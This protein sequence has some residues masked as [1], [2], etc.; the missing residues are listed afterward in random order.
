LREPW[1]RRLQDWWLA[2][3]EGGAAVDRETAGWLTSLA[4]HLG[5][6]LLLAVGTVYTQPVS[7]LLQ[8]ESTLVRDDQVDS[9]REYDISAEVQPE[10]GANSVRGDLAAAAAAPELA[11]VTEL[12]TPLPL[13]DRGA[14][15]Y[16][17]DIAEPVSTQVSPTDL[18]RGVASAGVTGTSGAIDRLTAEI[19][20]S[21]E[22][23]ETLVVW[24]FDQSGSLAKQREGIR[25][26][27]DRVYAELGS[28]AAVPERG[29]PPLLS[30]VVAYG[31]RTHF[32][33]DPTDDVAALKQAVAGIE[34]DPTGIEVTFGTVIQAVERF[35]SYRHKPPKRNV[36]L[37]VFTDEVGDDQPQLDAAVSLCQRHEMPVYVVGVPAPFG[38]D[39]VY[40][41]YVDPDP[42][43]DQSE[44]WLPV[45]QGPESYLPEALRLR[46]VGEFQ[47]SPPLDSGF[48]PYALTRLCYETGGIFF[49]VHPNRRPLLERG[50]SDVLVSNIEQFFE[51]ERM[52][53]YQPDYLSLRDYQKLLQA[54]RARQA[55]VEAARQTWIEPMENPQLVFPKLDDATLSALL[56]QAQQAAARLEPQVAAVYRV[57]EQGEA[58]RDRLTGERWRAGFDLAMGRI[59]AVKVRTEGYNAM[60]AQAKQGMKFKHEGSDTW[61]LRPADTISSGSA[62]AKQA[63]KARGYLERVVAEHAGTPWALLAARELE[64]PL[65]WEW[66]ERTTGVNRPRMVAQAGPAVPQ[67]DQARRAPPPPPRRDP[68][69]L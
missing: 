5:L 41:R 17:E 28:E 66:T 40:V 53:R 2:R 27:L 34:S 16:L 9:T 46:F 39:E 29:P 64:T 32:L 56:S 65:G 59:L 51:P 38:R 26:R 13:R 33:L 3:S 25:K 54:N 4:V 62:L 11:D 19:L 45:R 49:A 10:H 44:Q 47:D 42:K 30:A 7:M 37:I 69:K 55:L 48:G 63:A 14:I 23:R 6:L 15:E 67:D 61:V 43:F 50:N 60:L 36:M 20:R 31:Q 1:W 22:Q 18:V 68:P 12:P 21:L 57:L 8:L 35:Q 24:I 58:H 52:R